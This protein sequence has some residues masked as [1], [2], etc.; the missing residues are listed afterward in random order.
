[1]LE[2]IK[3]MKSRVL[4]WEHLLNS[5]VSI[6]GSEWE[7][8]RELPEGMEEK[9]MRDKMDTSGKQMQKHLLS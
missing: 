8:A 6:R 7:R 3:Q 9:V 5:D 2:D 1:M 4:E